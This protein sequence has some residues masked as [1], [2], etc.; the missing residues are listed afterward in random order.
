MGDPGVKYWG[1][2]TNEP[3]PKYTTAADSSSTVSLGLLTHAI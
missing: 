2:R 1:E 3:T